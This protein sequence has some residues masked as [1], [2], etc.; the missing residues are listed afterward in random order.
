[1][2]DLTVESAVA[3]SIRRFP[4]DLLESSV[5]PDLPVD[6]AAAACNHN[7]S[8]TRLVINQYNISI[9]PVPNN[10]RRYTIFWFKA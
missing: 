6:P 8:P 5:D 2:P 7:Q 10:G 3:T 4:S 1:M 9:E